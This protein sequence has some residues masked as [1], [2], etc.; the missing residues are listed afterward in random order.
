MPRVKVGY[1]TASRETYERFKNEHPDV[2]INFKQFVQ[3]NQEFNTQFRDYI[4]ET[5]DIAKYPFG[6]GDFS[7]T[8]KK[9]KK[10]KIDPNGVQR[11]NLP[12]DWKKTKELG[13]VIYTYNSHTQGFRCRWYWFILIAKFPL[14]QLFNFKP[15]RTTSR[16]LAEYLNKPNSPYLEIYKQFVK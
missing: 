4:L 9:P 11:V 6:L 3:I 16:K 10:Y 8:K 5:G 14:S 15:S 12:I 7:I 1:R 13:K 2:N